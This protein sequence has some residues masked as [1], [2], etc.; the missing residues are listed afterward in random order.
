MT[1]S[2]REALVEP[3]G[4]TEMAGLPQAVIFL[5]DRDLRLLLV[6]GGTLGGNRY[7]E[8]KLT[9][10]LLSDV[11]SL[12]DV[13]PL[14]G[15]YRAALAGRS[16]DLEYTSPVHG[17]QFRMRV[18]PVAG[19][20]GEIVSGLATIDDVSGD[21]AREVRLRQIHGLTP[22]GSCEYD[23][24]SGWVV[25][26]EL[27]ELWGVDSATDPLAVINGLVLP[28]DRAVIAS[29]WTDVLARGGRSSPHYRIRHGQTD[30]LRFVMC[31]CEAEVDPAG[32]LLRAISTHVDVSDAVAA[33]EVAEHAEAAAGQDRTMLRRINHAVATQDQRIDDEAGHFIV[34]PVRHEGAVLGQLSIFRTPDTPHRRGDEQPVQVLADRVGSALAE[35]RLREVRDQERAGRRAVADRLLEL[36]YEQRE[37]LEQLASTETRERALL[38]DAVHDDPMQM[39][40][41]AILRIDYLRLQMA[42]E[43]GAELDRVA[44]LLETSVERL[45]KLIVAI[46]PPDLGDGLGVALR[47]LAE[48]IFIGTASVVTVIG[49]THVSLNPQA[50][51][52]AYRVMREA[53]VNA[54]KHAEADHVMLR[55]EEHDSSVLLSLTDDGVGAT[56]LKAEPGHFGLAT[57]RARADAEDAQLHIDSTPGVGTTVLL[58][59]PVTK[60]L[61]R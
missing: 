31:T 48:G 2:A 30:E 22:F 46:T 35:S 18:R 19:P 21:R 33:R 26:R 28:E 20:G 6:M 54:R 39:I 10:R 41:A 3:F 27:L 4:P 12:P 8:D 13:D 43:Q 51:A 47:N 36:T 15:P 9:G 45:R 42:G 38:A 60:Y 14:D 55:L 34:A 7:E 1:T 44:T 25:D 11:L 29:T 57:M 40:V 58:T 53:L 17:G 32:V 50:K 5:F 24:R 16:S 52:T 59:L 56:S 23:L 61:A 49:P 37:L